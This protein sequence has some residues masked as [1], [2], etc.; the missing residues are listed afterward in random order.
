MD[1]SHIVKYVP[2][3]RTGFIAAVNKQAAK[4]G[5]SDKEILSVEIMGDLA[6]IVDRPFPS[7]IVKSQGTLVQKLEEV[8]SHQKIKQVA[9]SWFNCLCEI[10]YIELAHYL[11]HVK[12]RNHHE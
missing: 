5:I 7:S 4:Y 1:T 12:V 6:L 2:Q 8:E 3:A 9:Y 11:G 10:R